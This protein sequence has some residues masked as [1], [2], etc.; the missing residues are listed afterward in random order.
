MLGDRALEIPTVMARLAGRIESRGGR[1]HY[2]RVA[3]EASRGG[4]W[5]RRRRPGLWRAEH[6]GKSERPLVIP[7][8][9]PS[10]DGAMLPAQ[11]LDWDLG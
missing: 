10:E 4:T 6:A 1:R 9:L 8:D 5:P 3:V 2:V 11:M 7:E